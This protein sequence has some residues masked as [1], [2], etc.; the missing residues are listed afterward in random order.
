MIIK[1]GKTD[2]FLTSVSAYEPFIYCGYV[3]SW[4]YPETWGDVCGDIITRDKTKVDIIGTYVDFTDGFTKVDIYSLCQSTVRSYYFDVTSQ[5][6]Y[7][8]FSQDEGAPDAFNYEYSF[9]VCSQ[10]LG[11]NYVDDFEYLPIVKEVFD[12]EQ[13]AD[14]VGSSKPSGMTGSITLDNHA[15]FDYNTNIKKGLL[16]FLLDG[17]VFGNDIDIYDDDF[18]QLGSYVIDDY[19]VS[20]TETVLNIQDKRYG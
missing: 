20:E 19:E 14:A 16:D 7:M 6:I 10:K 12:F 13:Q 5:K 11:V 3:N 1:I 18:N 9:G 15:M 4:S 2:Y 8:H 17:S